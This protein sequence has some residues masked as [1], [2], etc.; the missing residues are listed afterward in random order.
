M[1]GRILAAL[2]AGAVLLTGCAEKPKPP[3]QMSFAETIVP[4]CYTVFP[5][6]DTEIRTPTADVP[7]DW[8]NF[9]GVWG[10]AAWEGEWCHDLHVLEV[11]PDGTAR[12]ISAHAPYD[13]W[14]REATIFRRTAKI[15]PDNRLR[16]KYG[17]T[18]HEYWLENGRLLGTR[19]IKEVATLHVSLGRKT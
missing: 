5:F 13:K 19:R 1:S 18:V 12:V 10:G 2:A 7:S 3:R 4:E 8:K 16:F 11:R 14:N 17:D 9:T 6:G 15:G